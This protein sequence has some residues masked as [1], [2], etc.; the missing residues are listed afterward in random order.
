M[1]NIA[2][3]DNTPLVTTVTTD[4]DEYM[5]TFDRLGDNIELLE[6][7]SAELSEAGH[8]QERVERLTAYVAEV[9]KFN[10]DVYNMLVLMH[11]IFHEDDK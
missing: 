1:D 2:Q 6:Q 8:D 9:Q 4:A 3:D 7:L 10:K 5:Q 11:N